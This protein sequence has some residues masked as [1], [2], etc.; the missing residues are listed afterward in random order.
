M[1]TSCFVRSPR[2]ISSIDIGNNVKM[3]YVIQYHAITCTTASLSMRILKVVA[4]RCNVHAFTVVIISWWFSLSNANSALIQQGEKVSAA[5]FRGAGLPRARYTVYLCTAS[6]SRMDMGGS[7]TLHDK[8]K[9][10][11]CLNK[12]VLF[13]CIFHF[14]EYYVPMNVPLSLLVPQGM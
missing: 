2:T 3:S 4:T 8:W 13:R 7:L 9:V 6:R 1:T 5:S 14:P 12:L 11:H 10:T